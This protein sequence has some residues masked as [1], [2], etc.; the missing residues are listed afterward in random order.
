MTS[1]YIRYFLDSNNLIIQPNSPL[2]TS[3]IDSQP[4]GQFM[5]WNRRF[6]ILHGMSRLAV[7]HQLAPAK[8]PTFANQL[9]SIVAANMVDFTGA[10]KG[11]T[12]QGK[13][14]YS[15]TYGKYPGAGGTS[16]EEVA[17]VHALYDYFGSFLV[18][19][20]GIWG[21][22]TK[23]TSASRLAKLLCPIIADRGPFCVDL[24][25]T[26]Q[27]KVNFGN[28]TFAAC[29]F[30]LPSLPVH[31]T[32][33]LYHSHRRYNQMAQTRCRTDHVDVF[34][35]L[36]GQERDVDVVPFQEGHPP[37]PPLR[38]FRLFL[39]MGTGMVHHPD[40][41]FPDAPVLFDPFERR[42]APLDQ[43]RPV[44]QQGRLLARALWQRQGGRVP[45]M[46]CFI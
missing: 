26:L 20:S 6:M 12:A 45:V 9:S 17:G 16:V 27:Y 2:W 46:L 32:D 25:N 44:R 38:R 1:Y 36:L 21:D 24:A 23:L 8:N 13:H 37:N 30:P 33:V 10:L 15:W 43:A 40:R 18:Y 19:Q 39:P 31:A 41:G 34:R 22:N 7:A 14:T 4:A 5:P 11:A 35:L 29:R 28:G 42:P 3:Q